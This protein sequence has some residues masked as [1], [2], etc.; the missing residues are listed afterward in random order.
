MLGTNLKHV[1]SS[2]HDGARAPRVAAFRQYSAGMPPRAVSGVSPVAVS[3]AAVVRAAAR[4]RDVRHR[5]VG[6]GLQPPV[7]PGQ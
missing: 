3:T 1:P 2:G 6:H 7:A 4:S 5:S